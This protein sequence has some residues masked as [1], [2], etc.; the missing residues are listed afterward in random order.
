MPFESAVP[1]RSDRPALAL[2][3]AAKGFRG[4][5]VR[6]GVPA[7]QMP[8]LGLDAVELERRLLEIGF[9][10]GAPVEIVH[11]GWIGRDPIA[12]RVNETTVALRRHEANAIL[13]EPAA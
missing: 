1:A 3:A 8:S 4:R 5:V 12:I 11:Q 7:D 13:V 2:G 10:E 9:V 6:I